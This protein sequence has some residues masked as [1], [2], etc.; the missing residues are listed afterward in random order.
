MSDTDWTTAPEG[1]VR[2]IHRSAEKY[3]DALLQI[4]LA[5]DQRA[6]NGASLFIA[7]AV[8]TAGAT[9]AHWARF[10]NWAVFGGGMA[11]AL[12][13]GIAAYC[14]LHAGRPV[15]FH[16]AGNE[17]DSWSGTLSIPLPELVGA[18]CENYQE[19]IEENRAAL[20]RNAECLQRGYVYGVVAPLVGAS[21]FAAIFFS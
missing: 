5:A 14:C 11:T 1:H 16:C 21:V 13:M 12:V 20:T 18:E 9:L 19:I 10:H 8:G 4:A 3:L 7:I 15:D 2:E 17:P 6:S